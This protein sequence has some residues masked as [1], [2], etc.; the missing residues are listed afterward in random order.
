MSSIVAK[1]S[2]DSID[3]FKG[4]AILLVVL[5]HSIQ[6]FSVPYWVTVV[7]SIGQL[8]CQVFFV[9]SSFSWYECS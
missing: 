1:K 2:I 8:G 6:R 4:V 3:F 7:P 5:V 9:L